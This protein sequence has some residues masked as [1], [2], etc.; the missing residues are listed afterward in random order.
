MILTVIGDVDRRIVT[1]TLLSFSARI[2]LT[3][4]VTTDAKAGKIGED[5][6]YQDTCVTKVEDINDYD[7]RQESFNY[8]YFVF[9]GGVPFYSDIVFYVTAQALTKKDK[10]N[11]S[12][13]KANNVIPVELYSTKTSY[14]PQDVEQRLKAFETTQDYP[15][16]S[17][18]L[19]EYLAS[20]MSKAVYIREPNLYVLLAGAPKPKKGILPFKFPTKRR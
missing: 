19:C 2:G 14:I 8:K 11:M 16:V 18:A 20:Q 9:D 10:Q 5:G 13:L 7:I 12:K 3:S 4:F 6:F 17:E 1:Y 15:C